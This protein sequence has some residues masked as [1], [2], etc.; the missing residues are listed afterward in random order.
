MQVGAF[1]LQFRFD[2]LLRV[3]PGAAGVG[4]EDG[5][6]QAEQRNGDQIADEE[7]RFEKRKRKRREEN[8]EENVEH[9]LL[10]ILRA[11]LDHL[12]AV[13]DR[14]LGDALEPDVGLDEL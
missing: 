14:S 10:R 4:H 1:H 3:I 6:E 2:N 13:F 9:P 11:N 12:A 8:T 7:K 5:L